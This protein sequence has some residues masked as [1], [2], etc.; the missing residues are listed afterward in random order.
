M[1]RLAA[2]F[3]CAISA[4]LT[5]AIPLGV[6]ADE[7]ESESPLVFTSFTLNGEAHDAVISSTTPSVAIEVSAP[8]EAYFTRLYICPEDAEPCN[9]GSAT[10]FFS[11]NATTT[12]F[13]KTWDGEMSGGGKA[14]AGSYHLVARFFRYALSPDAF[15]ETAPFFIAVLEEEEEE[16]DDTDESDENDDDD[17]EE[18]ESSGSDDDAP[19][20]IPGGDFTCC[21]IDSD[22]SI[23]IGGEEYEGPEG[24]YDFFET[25]PP[26][27]AIAGDAIESPSTTLTVTFRE[28]ENP[29]VPGQIRTVFDAPVPA[30]R[31]VYVLHRI[32]SDPT[33]ENGPEGDT[34]FPGVNFSLVHAPIPANDGDPATVESATVAFPDLP[35]FGTPSALSGTYRISVFEYPETKFVYDPD[36]DTSTEEPYTDADFLSNYE[37]R[38]INYDFFEGNTPAYADHSPENEATF[39]IEYTAA[40]GPVYQE[41]CSSVVFLPG[42]E[43]SI[44]KTGDN[45]LWPPTLGEVSDDLLHLSLLPD[46]NPFDATVV[47]D[48][49]LETFSVGPFGESIYRG[50]VSFMDDLI[51]NDGDDIAIKEWKALPY[52]WRFSPEYILEHGIQTPDALID[53]MAT[54]EEIARDSYTGQVTIVGHSMGGLMG[55]AIIKELEERDE[56]DLIDSFVMVGTPQ[57]GTPQAMTALL[58]GEGSQ[59]PVVLNKEAARSLAYNMQS[60]Y[61]LLPSGQYFSHITDP[62]ATFDPDTVLTQ[63]WRDV[64]GRAIGNVA[65][66]VS[67][68][69]GDGPDRA[70]P[71]SGDTQHPEMLRSDLVQEAFDLHEDFDS[72]EFPET[73]RVVQ[74]AGWGLQTIKGIKYTEDKGKFDYEIQTTVEGDKTVLYPSALS[75]ETLNNYFVQLTNYNRTVSIHSQHRNLVSAEPILNI[76]TA[77]IK[78]S[79]IGGI[80]FVTKTKPAV[81][82]VADSLLV[83]AHSPV[84]LGVYDEFGNFTGIALGQDAHA[85]LLFVQED[86][87]GSSYIQAGEGK[88]LLLPEGG[89]YSFTLQGTDVGTATIKFQFISDDNAASTTA[90]YSNISITSDTKILFAIDTSAS[91]TVEMSVDTDGDGVADSTIK[92]DEVVAI[93]AKEVLAQ[94]EA[95]ARNSDTIPAAG[96]GGPLWVSAPPVVTSPPPP[97]AVSVLNSPPPISSQVIVPSIVS[98]APSK[99][100]PK[101]VQPSPP[102]NAEQTTPAHPAQSLSGQSASVIQSGWYDL[103][104]SFA[105]SVFDAMVRFVRSALNL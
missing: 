32:V 95:E 31:G 81:S 2:F 12:A 25:F 4:I 54:I 77:V 79:V 88:Y 27:V 90:T 3:V 20:D 43:G 71:E 66:Y 19:S 48:G 22:L 47:V 65:E 15:E 33:P 93:E 94:A 75:S 14:P 40:S 87:P 72:Y 39:T 1:R 61:N 23:A 68:L 53:I 102:E 49:V 76:I 103:F 73:I 36:T 82:D 38:F 63:T 98:V 58:H 85:D 51:A 37:W 100:N 21:F 55:K 17:E 62:V 52:D 34:I 101:I 46:G 5:V 97:P 96:G 105:V 69:T 92:S 104:V 80:D 44:L 78:E 50:F 18:D 74:V 16:V 89:S 42:F 13:S 57:L 11:P 7:V 41:C 67:F 10:K 99:T 70:R 84:T 28:R 24:I 64:W 35:A 59:I 8:E 86:I 56:A 30:E 6:S 91:Q 29:D 45:T 83:S 9:Q 60:A 26:P